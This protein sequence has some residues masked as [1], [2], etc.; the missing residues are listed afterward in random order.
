M[1]SSFVRTTSGAAFLFAVALAVAG[2]ARG[3]RQEGTGMKTIEGHVWYRER[4][5]LPPNAEILVFLEDVAR[6]DVPSE[7]IATTRFEPEGGP[8]WMFSL[9][10]DPHRLQDKGRY[11]LRARIEADGRLLFINTASIPAFQGNAGGPVQV[12]VS[13]VGGGREGKGARLPDASL[14]E[15]YWKLIELDGQAAVVGAGGRELHMVLASDGSRVHGFLGC[16]RFTGN[17][18]RTGGQLSFSQLASTRMAC[19]EGMELE[20]RFLD[21]LGRTS[22]FRIRGDQLTLYSAD[23]QQTMRFLAVALQ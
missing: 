3:E 18:Q 11:V 22:R 9:E 6:M 13:R 15:T 2:V 7:V 21:A 8:P 23:G 10:Y 5:A 14:T 12:L 1:A 19:M 20:Q 16:N 17:Y 4:I